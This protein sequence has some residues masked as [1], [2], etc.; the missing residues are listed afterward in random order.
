MG[1]I[2]KSKV[3]TL[4]TDGG[5]F[6]VKKTG[7][8]YSG[9]YLKTSNNTYYAGADLNDLSVQLVLSSENEVLPEFG[10]SFNCIKYISRKQEIY[11]NLKKTKIVPASKNIPSENDYKR[12]YFIRYFLVRVNDLDYKEINV[13]IYNEMLMKNQI[14]RNLYFK[15]QIKWALSG[16]VY[17]INTNN[18][19]LLE[20]KHPGIMNLF[21][22][23]NEFSKEDS[24]VIT[25]LHTA[26]N[27]LYYI[28]GAEYI[29]FYH[30]HPEKGPMIGATHSPHPHAKLYYS[31]E[32]FKNEYLGIDSK[33]FEEFNESLL[34]PTPSVLPP[35]FNAPSTIQIKNP[36]KSPTT[37]GPTIGKS[38]SPA[39][40]PSSGGS[41]SSGGSSGGGGY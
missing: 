25:N 28:D 39:P 16:D 11:N 27:E 4:T 30:I 32:I 31:N 2:P 20:K 36:T 35:G 9:P 10:N 17:K 8:S 41:V 1:Y 38:V 5:E 24:P 14:D 7:D 29:G 6:L 13:N 15:G 21:P 3:K 22:I 40:S 26:G 18:L 12:G 23:L 34:R 37:Q 33:E 19:L